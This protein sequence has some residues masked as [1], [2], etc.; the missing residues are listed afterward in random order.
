MF[1]INKKQT[2]NKPDKTN[3][4][5]NVKEAKIKVGKAVV[6]DLICKVTKKF[7]NSN[8]S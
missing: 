2:K 3:N 7:I 5:T 4:K 8:K 6:P 1:G